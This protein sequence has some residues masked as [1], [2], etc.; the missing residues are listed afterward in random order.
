MEDVDRA[1]QMGIS[2]EEY[3]KAMATMQS[4]VQST[5]DLIANVS[6]T[7][8]KYKG[9]VLKIEMNTATIDKLT[10]ENIELEHQRTV[11]EKPYRMLK[12]A[13]DFAGIEEKPVVQQT[14]VKHHRN[15]ND[16]KYDPLRPLFAKVVSGE[17]SIRE[18]GVE[19]KTNYE[20]RFG[21]IADNSFYTLLNRVKKGEIRSS[22]QI[23][24]QKPQSQPIVIR[25]DLLEFQKE[26]VDIPTI[27]SVL[28]NQI[29]AYGK[30]AI[31]S[32]K[33][34]E[35]TGVDINSCEKALTDMCNERKVF[36]V[37]GTNKY[38]LHRNYIELK[39]PHLLSRIESSY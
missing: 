29:E 39:Y 7:V 1:G 24:K 2:N 22:L 5:E 20:S 12:D 3:D 13:F 17:M 30:K 37:D 35:L 28:V 16:A 38:M 32:F 27:E 4:H 33:I 23:E 34:S 8:K 31:P 26:N 25:K 19:Y 21:P 11:L 6:E 9:I 10:K 36:N 18:F 15:W 14:G